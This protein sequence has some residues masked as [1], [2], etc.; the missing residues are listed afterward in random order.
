RASSARKICRS[1]LDAITDPI[2]IFD[3]QT[4]RIIDVNEKA[5]ELYKYSRRELVGKQLQDLT[6]EI[7]TYAELLH[8]PPTIGATHFSSTGDRLEFLV[9]LSLVEYWGRKAALSI[10]RDIREMKQ[11]QATLTANERK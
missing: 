11:I 9:S 7:P 6:N 8:P 1:I 4:Y 10:N 2:L 3:P 5:T